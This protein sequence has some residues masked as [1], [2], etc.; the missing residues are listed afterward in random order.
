LFI[1]SMCAR[2]IGF[3]GLAGAAVGGAPVLP[4]PFD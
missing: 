3:P 4:A 1:A 2:S